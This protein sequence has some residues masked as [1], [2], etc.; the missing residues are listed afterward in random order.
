EAT[1]EHKAVYALVLVFS[2]A[3]GALAQDAAETC[4]MLPR[5]RE[6]CGFPGVTAAQCESRGCCFDDTVRGFPWCFHPKA[7]ESPPEETCEF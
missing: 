7:V 6:N 2:L 1:M 3:L 4:S 5:E